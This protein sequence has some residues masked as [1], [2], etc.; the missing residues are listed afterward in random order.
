MTDDAINVLI[1]NLITLSFFAFSLQVHAHLAH[2]CK[3]KDDN[4]KPN[5]SI[6]SKLKGL[7]L[8]IRGLYL[9][10]KEWINFLFYLIQGYMFILFS[11]NCHAS[12]EGSF[13]LFYKKY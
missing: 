2:K 11:F 12:R 13:E 9:M 1:M 10:K 5:L 7:D 6:S 4:C 8:A 3:L